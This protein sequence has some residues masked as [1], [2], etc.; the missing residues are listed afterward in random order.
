MSDGGDTYQARTNTPQ[1]PPP[2]QRPL[3]LTLV[4]LCLDGGTRGCACL[5]LVLFAGRLHS[6]P[7]VFFGCLRNIRGP[8]VTLTFHPVHHHSA[9]RCCWDLTWCQHSFSP[10]EGTLSP[11]QSLPPSCTAR[12]GAGVVAS[13]QKSP[14]LVFPAGPG[15]W[16]GPEL[17]KLPLCQPSLN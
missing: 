12:P 1:C 15:S 6:C 16:A 9:W 5:W 7:G 11:P 2:P 10:D 17:C 8:L 14:Q 13:L 3:S 4:P